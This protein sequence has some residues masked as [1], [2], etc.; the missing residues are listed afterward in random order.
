MTDV[1]ML[2]ELVATA[3]RENRK[4]VRKQ[5]AIV[6]ASILVSLK[7]LAAKALEPIPATWWAFGILLGAIVKQQSYARDGVS[8]Q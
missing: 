4:S 1:L 7:S 5:K 3:L 2:Q 8:E 6:D